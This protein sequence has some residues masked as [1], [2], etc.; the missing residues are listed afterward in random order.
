[1]KPT[2]STQNSPTNSLGVARRRITAAVLLTSFACGCGADDPATNDPGASNGNQTLD[3]APVDLSVAFEIW[4]I[5]SMRG[6]RVGYSHVTVT[7]GR[8]DGE[9]VLRIDYHNHI[10]VKRLNEEVVMDIR[11]ASVE[12]LDGRLIEFSAEAPLGLTPQTTVGRVVDGQLRLEVTSPNKTDRSSIPWNAECGGPYAVRLSLL[13]EPLAPGQRRRVDSITPGLNLLATTEMTAGEYEQVELPAG[14]RQLLRIDAKTS[15][16]GQ[17]LAQ[18]LWMDRSG[19]VFMEQD[20]TLAMK[21][22]RATKADAL[23]DAAPTSFDL[24]FDVAVRVERSLTN[25]HRTRRVRYRVRLKDGD[26]SRVFARGVSQEV[27]RIDD[28]T[29]EIIVRA[30]TPKTLPDLAVADLPDDPPTAADLQPNSLIESDDARIVA[31]AERAAA[32]QQ[33]PWSTAVALERFVRGHMKSGGPVRAFATAAEVAENGQGDCTEYAVLLTALARA[34][35][36]PARLAIGLVYYGQS[37]AYHAWTEVHVDGH[38]IPLDATLAQGGLGGAHIKVAHTNLDG[39]AAL[40]AFLPVIQVIGKL[41][42][43]IV[44][45]E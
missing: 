33:D 15:L 8:H 22:V 44:E 31:M 7:P 9:D 4:E 26:P 13:R 1:M 34:R 10:A 18:T 42:I 32:G 2:Q 40:A 20:D 39:V 16:A 45:V 38:W 11:F 6:Q 17:T 29:A 28:H 37:Y 25:P 36:I 35:G 21:S 24:G 5:I 41:E 30:V 19:Q 3:A 23:A 12:T 14:Q 43:E 27:K